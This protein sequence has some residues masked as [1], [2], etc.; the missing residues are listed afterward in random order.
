MDPRDEATAPRGFGAQLAMDL[1][2]DGEPATPLAVHEAAGG[3]YARWTTEEI[4]RLHFVLL[5]DLRRLADADTPLEERF[6]L[7]EW[8]FSEAAAASRPFS[9]GACVRLFSR[10]CD[11]DLAR[12]AIRPI[13]RAGLEAALAKYPAWLAERVLREPH[14]AADGLHRDPQWINEALA[15]ARREPDLFGDADVQ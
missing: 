12:E 4:V 3:E 15:R 9:F 10:T 7:L 14:W 6:E 1:A 2:E 5:D 11:P 8:V 13:A